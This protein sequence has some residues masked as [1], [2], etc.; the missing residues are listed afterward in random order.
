MKYLIAETTIKNIG[1]LDKKKN[2]FFRYLIQFKK[3][4]KGKKKIK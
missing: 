3:T 2:V 1:S 4:Y